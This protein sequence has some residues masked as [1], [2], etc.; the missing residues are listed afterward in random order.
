M[1]NF[2]KIARLDLDTLCNENGHNLSL[3]T[4][5]CFLVPIIIKCN[6]LVKMEA[7]TLLDFNTLTC[8]IDKKLVATIQVCS[9]EKKHISVN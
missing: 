7:Q 3:D 6:K 5:P 4:T 2:N 8:F 9:N 1:F